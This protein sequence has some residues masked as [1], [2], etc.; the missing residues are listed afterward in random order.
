MRFR[1]VSGLLLALGAALSCGGHYTSSGRDE[2]SGA[3]AGSTSGG[4]PSSGQAASG[5]KPSGRPVDRGGTSSSAGSVSVGGSVIG[6]AGVAVGGA[7]GT[8]PIG[9]TDG[10]VPV[11]DGRGCFNACVPGE[12]LNAVCQPE[13]CDPGTHLEQP[14]DQ[15]CPICVSDVKLD[16]DEAKLEYLKLRAAVIAKYQ[17]LGCSQDWE[18]GAFFE[19]NRCYQSCGTPIPRSQRD[20]AEEDTS[21]WAA[22][23]CYVCPEVAPT[24][25]PMLPAPVCVD[26]TCQIP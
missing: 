11:F 8:G 13:P 7:C 6:T 15:C 16:C 26:G 9:C 5:G 22:A 21:N 23:H 2:A 20:L 12:C 25:C 1:S 24:P 3:G 4:K 17:K 18:C 19:S 14:A 10:F